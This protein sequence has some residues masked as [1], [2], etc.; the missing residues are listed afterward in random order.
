MRSAN[1]FVTPLT[2]SDW[3]GS[4]ATDP[5]GRT[6]TV[7]RVFQV[8]PVQVAVLTDSTPEACPIWDTPVDLLAR[9]GSAAAFPEYREQSRT[10]DGL[11][12]HMLS[13]GT[14]G[15]VK[16]RYHVLLERLAPYSKAQ[17]SL[18]RFLTGRLVVGDRVIDTYK[19]RQG[20]LLDPNPEPLPH[21]TDPMIVHFEKPPSCDDQRWP[22]GIAFL[23]IQ[24]LYPSLGLL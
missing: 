20:T 17:H 9:D 24:G 19:G 7:R 14:S 21:I 13:N 23:S 12:L 18:H 11:R 5:Y 6:G 4:T 10:M 16:D 1:D 2:A 3:L 22:D 15:A 8:G